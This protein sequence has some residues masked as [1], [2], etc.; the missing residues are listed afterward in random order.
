MELLMVACLLALLAA[1]FLPSFVAIFNSGADSQ[2]YNV[3]A[4]QLM[5]ARSIAVRESIFSAVHVQIA[6]ASAHPDLAGAQ[7]A[8]VMVPVGED[9]TSSGFP[10]RN[11]RLR[12][13]YT[14]Q[15]I[16]GGMGFGELGSD[17]VS[18][19][20]TAGVFSAYSQLDDDR[21]ADFMTFTIVFAPGG[22]VAKQVVNFEFNNTYAKSKLFDGS[23]ATKRL[24]DQTL[25]ESGAES[26]VYGLTLFRISDILRLS[27]Q[28]RADS[29]NRNAQFLPINVYTGQ[30]FPRF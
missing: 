19:S 6:D 5:M 28:D 1:T 3:M 20:Q 7:F 10:S 18:Q 25:S 26:S 24:W 21:L 9:D 17:F 16:P 30:L 8:A 22:A 11:F 2:A 23:D 15:R 14:P 13:G 4:A 12:E 29:L 27:A